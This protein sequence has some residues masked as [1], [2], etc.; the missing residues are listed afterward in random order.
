MTL[1]LTVFQGRV[2]DHNDRGFAGASAIGA[3]WQRWLGLTAA[4]VGTP[5]AP[6]NTG[7][8]A[9]LIAATP[10]LEEM[11]HRDAAIYSAGHTPVSAVPGRAVPL[12]AFPL[13]PGHRAHGGPLQLGAAREHKA[14][15]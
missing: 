7:W 13:V 14:P 2:G 11:S 6:L 15:G 4:T 3:E 1:A 9:E 10:T 12:A 8:R 5:E